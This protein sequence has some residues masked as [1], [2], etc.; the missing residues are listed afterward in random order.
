[1]V[2]V[3]VIMPVYNTDHKLLHRAIKSILNQ[4]LKEIELILVDD[5]SSNG[6]ENICDKYA[7]LDSRVKVLHQKNS[8]ICAARNKAIELAKGKYIGF[9][10]HDDE[11][12]T[13]Q[14]KDN[15][16][17]AC[18]YDVD[19]I[20]FNY[21]YICLDNL[22]K[23]PFQE[24]SAPSET[25]EVIQEK[26]LVKKYEILKECGILTF[27]WDA[28][29]NKS[30]L[31]EHNLLFDTYFKIGQED[32]DFNNKSYIHIKRLVYNPKVYY[33]HYR[34]PKSTSRGMNKEKTFR[35]IKDEVEIFEREIR[36]CQKMKLRG[37]DTNTINSM[38][39]RNF[40]VILST[41]AR[42]DFLGTNDEK[43]AILNKLNEQF[44]S[45]TIS[46]ISIQSVAG[47]SNKICFFLFL[48]K[49]YRILYMLLGLY[50]TIMKLIK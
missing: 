27:V 1:M 35:L 28:L 44:F 34:Y 12:G 47:L 26:A 49:Q 40:L 13:D 16:Q 15:Y 39:Y 17:L 11:Y 29:Y 38:Y 8:G 10:D 2:A 14:L 42:N 50:L 19:V 25:Y 20:K 24:Y 33:K 36:S 4:S 31:H 7:A 30:F 41:T 3:S 32:I 22:P 5:G 43:R 21:S 37:M 18:K 48:K 23:F 6:S 46:P 45:S 9:C